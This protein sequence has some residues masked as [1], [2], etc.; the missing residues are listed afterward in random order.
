MPAEGWLS[1]NDWTG[2]YIPFDGLPN[3]L[4]PEEGFIVTANQAVIDDDYPYFLT[5][6]WDFGYRSTRIRQL[7]AG[8]G[9]AVGRRDDPAA[10]R[11]RQPDGGDAGALPPR[12]RGPRLGLLPRR[13][14]APRG[15]GLHAAGGQRGRGLLQR[16]VEQSPAAHLPRRPARG[17]LAQR[18]R[19][20]VRRGHQPARATRPDRGGT[21]PTTEDVVESRDDI[22][23][24]AMLDARDE[25]TKRQALDPDDWTWGHLHQLD[26]HNATLG[27]SG[28]APIERLFNRDGNG[29]GG[30]SSIVDA[31]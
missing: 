23:R 4:D 29:V 19:P 6:D 30:G 5:D 21:T 2:D 12:H 11:H 1:A 8:R 16:R 15:L 20:V 27:E 10:A 22:L 28:I 18:R 26:L 31:T 24:Q 14:G 3:V 9:R 25:L 17:H 13:P 7:L